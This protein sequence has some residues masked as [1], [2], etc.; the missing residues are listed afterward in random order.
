M[1]DSSTKKLE[2][3]ARAVAC[4]HW[5][6]MPGMAWYV[7]GAEWPWGRFLRGELWE[8]EEFNPCKDPDALPDL[9]D[10][11]TLGCIEHGLLPSVGY[12]DAHIDACQGPSG[13]GALYF[14]VYRPDP[15]SFPCNW[16][17][18]A[19]DGAPTKDEALVAALE[20]AP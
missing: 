4:K 3:A 14:V 7:P 19:E 18:A 20:A 17:S 8:L 6:W 1:E 12:N 9:D 13:R 16:L 2:L 5:R 11:A 15:V 10:P